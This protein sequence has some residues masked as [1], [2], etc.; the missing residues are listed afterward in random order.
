MAGFLLLSEKVPDGGYYNEINQ[1]FGNYSRRGGYVRA[2]A[3][4]LVPQ[5]RG[6]AASARDRS[7]TG[8]GD[9]D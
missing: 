9:R 6:N 7:S 1:E 3:W 8:T 2:R 5:D 4:L